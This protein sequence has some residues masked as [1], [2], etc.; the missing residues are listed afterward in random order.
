[1]AED[2]PIPGKNR[3]MGRRNDP[4]RGVGARRRDGRRLSLGSHWRADG[5]PKAVFR[6]KQDALRAANVRHLESGVTLNVYECDFCS[7]WHL[8]SSSPRER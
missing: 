2:A 3:N 7:S 1:M 6:S 4:T 8:G 5:A